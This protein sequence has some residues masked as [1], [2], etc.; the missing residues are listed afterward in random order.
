[1]DDPAPLADTS[2][3]RVP[4]HVLSRKVADETVLL[5]LDN[6]QYYGL[7]GVGT[8]FWD[9]VEAGTTLGQAVERLL[10]DYDVDRDV[11]ARDLA[12]VAVDLQRNGLLLV[13]AP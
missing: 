2:I 8:R 4:D 12:A 6:E 3:L 11:L 9:L 1:M 5:N 13:D 10:G 7:E